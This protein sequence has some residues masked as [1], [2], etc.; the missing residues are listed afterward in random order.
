MNDFKKLSFEQI[1]KV[2]HDLKQ[3]FDKIT[4][5][6]L[7]L[8][9]DR[10][11]PCSEQ[12]DLSMPMLKY[13]ETSNFIS[14][15]ALDCRNYG[16]IDGV[17]EAKKLFSDYLEVNT[18]EICIGGNSSLSMMY[19]TIASAIICGFVDSDLQWGKLPSIKF[20]C[21]SPGYD[22]H[23]FICDYLGIDM[24]PINMTNSGPDMNEVI[25][26]A[27]KDE[28]IKGIW[29]VPKYSNPTGITYSDEVV[30]QLATMPTKAKDFKIFW[31]NAYAVHHLTEKP[32]K[33]K[34]ILVLLG[35]S[36]ILIY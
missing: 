15:N 24:I 5:K 10:G 14:E 12:L 33:L 18:D 1:L 20:L 4:S 8:S 16:G 2:E 7:I 32:K 30:E 25:R 9:L 29:C 3:R 28:F 36:V 35:F 6:K 27:S 22:R 31:D 23:F 34:N 11:K 26:Q 17:P 21:P 13:D 19:D